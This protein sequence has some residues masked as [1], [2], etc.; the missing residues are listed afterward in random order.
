MYGVAKYVVFP[1]KRSIVYEEYSANK[2][3]HR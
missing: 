2:G 1:C 3:L